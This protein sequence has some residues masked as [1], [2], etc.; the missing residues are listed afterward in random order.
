V[1]R[2]LHSQT[3]IPDVFWRV[4]YD[5]EVKSRREEFWELTERAW[6]V[7]RHA[8]PAPFMRADWI[9]LMIAAARYRFRQ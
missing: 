9:M 4:S 3:L 7:G 8:D 6:H 1:S 5:G 2:N